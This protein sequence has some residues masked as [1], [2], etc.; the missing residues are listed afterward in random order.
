MDEPDAP[1][2]HDKLPP[3]TV[4]KVDV[5]LQL[6]TTVTTGVDGIAVCA[7]ITTFA[8]AKEVHPAVLVTVKL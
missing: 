7:S 4:D 1:V 6:L 2:L 3:A 5:P 8:V